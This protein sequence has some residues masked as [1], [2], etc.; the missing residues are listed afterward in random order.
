M[1]QPIEVD[2]LRRDDREAVVEM[3]ASSSDFDQSLMRQYSSAGAYETL[4]A[5]RG[6]QVEGVISGSFRGDLH[7]SREFAQF[8][9]PPGP[10]GFV[11]RVHVRD[12]ARG[13]GVGRALVQAF[14]AHARSLRCTFVGGFI[15][16]SDDPHGRRRFFKRVGFTVKPNDALGAKIEDLLR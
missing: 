8:T 15:D 12:E 6:S 2:L 9:L 10:H 5:R 11:A 16:R 4:F 13:E 3:L 14:A 7:D 1:M